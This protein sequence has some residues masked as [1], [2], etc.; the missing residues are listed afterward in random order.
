MPSAGCIVKQ[1]E[2]SLDTDQICDF[3]KS[4]KFSVSQFSN[5]KKGFDQVIPKIS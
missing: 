5:H 3:G 2:W 4:V 1:E